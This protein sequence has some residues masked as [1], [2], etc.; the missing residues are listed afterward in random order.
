MKSENSK[1][2]LLEQLRKIPIVEIACRQCSI[3]SATYYRW[4]KTNKKFRE[5]SDQALKDGIRFTNDM[6]ESKLIKLLSEGN[7]RAI[8]FWLKHRHNSYKERKELD[9]SKIRETLT[10]TENELLDEAIKRLPFQQI[11][12]TPK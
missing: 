6:A 1:K 7:L 10:A 11:Y 9:N 2:L 12:D 3:S 4:R 8:I 5:Q